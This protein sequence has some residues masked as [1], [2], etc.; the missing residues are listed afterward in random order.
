MIE[1]VIMIDKRLNT[2]R[3]MTDIYPHTL[4]GFKYQCFLSPSLQ[5][6]RESTSLRVH[7]SSPS[8]PRTP[9]WPRARGRRYLWWWLWTEGSRAR[10]GLSATQST[11]AASPPPLRP[12]LHPTASCSSSLSSSSPR[13]A[14]LRSPFPPQ[15]VFVCAERWWC[16]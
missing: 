9:R 7:T 8:N 6:N 3:E 13:A 5:S 10:T 12:L 14:P 15:F 1:H 11:P 16:F 2:E 4:Y